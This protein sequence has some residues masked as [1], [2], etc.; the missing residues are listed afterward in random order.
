MGPPCPQHKSHTPTTETANAEKK[1]KKKK[2]TMATTTN[3]MEEFDY[4]EL[5][6][7]TEN[8]SSSRVIGKG[9]HGCIYKGVLKDGKVVAIKKWSVGLKNLGDNSKLENE[10]QVLSSLP[11]ETTQN[12]VRLLGTSHDMDNNKVMVMG[13]M[14]NCSL[15]DLFHRNQAAPPPPPCWTK[16]AQIAVQIAKAVQSLHNARPT[17]IHRDIKSANVLFDDEWNAKLADFGLAVRVSGGI[18][19]VHSV[20]QPAGTIGYLDPSY[21]AP[22]KLSTKNDVFSFGVLLL[23]IVSGRKAIDTSKSPA[24]VVE[25]ALPLIRAGKGSETRDV[26][27]AWPSYVGSGVSYMLGVAAS[28]V[29]MIEDDRPSMDD[30]VTRLETGYVERVR[31]PVWIHFARAIVVL[32]KRRSRGFRRCSSAATATTTTLIC[33][34]H[35]GN[36]ETDLTRRKMLLREVLALTTQDS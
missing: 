34:A 9:S 21:T 7:A 2:M 19:R 36:I 8:F 31:F 35:T 5:R 18:H 17:V 1:R 26:R 4:E 25:W 24:S 16:R 20:S 29:S 32:R 33:A 3:I 11:P 6:K 13:Y 30:V 23:E 22:H 14:P 28:C 15:H 10:V 27:I 12:I